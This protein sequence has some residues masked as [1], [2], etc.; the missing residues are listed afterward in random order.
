MLIDFLHDQRTVNAAYYCQLLQ[1]TKAKYRTKRRDMAIRDVI[2]LHDNA[3][4]H[5]AN[6]TKEKLE[7]M[8]WETLDHP[9]YSPDL[10]PCDYFL[11]APLK[12]S[13]GGERFANNEDVE[14]RVRNWLMT[15]PHTFFQQGMFKHPNRWQKC[16]ELQGDYIEK[17]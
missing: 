9:P 6:L 15:R 7:N 12:E 1:S 16:V 5:T 13:L 11:F 17:N 8:H 4:P 10:S 2:L 14:N 3:R